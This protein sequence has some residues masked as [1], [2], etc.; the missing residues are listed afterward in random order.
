MATEGAKK[1]GG[2]D[3]AFSRVPAN[4]AARFGQRR[5]VLA[6]RIFFALHARRH[7]LAVLSPSLSRRHRALHG[8]CLLPR[9]SSSAARIS[10]RADAVPTGLTAKA[11]RWTPASSLQPLTHDTSAGTKMYSRQILGS[12]STSSPVQME[13]QF[14]AASDESL[15]VVITYLK[16]NAVGLLDLFP[17]P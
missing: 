6:S 2:P 15:A 16:A 7:R 4:P 14:M 11:P 10:R 5:R 1:S 8:G 9:P 12:S 17:P 13:M 3:H